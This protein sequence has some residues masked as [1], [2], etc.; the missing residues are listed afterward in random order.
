M[1][2]N[3]TESLGRMPRAQ[4]NVRPVSQVTMAITASDL[5]VQFG[6]VQQEVLRW[7]R[8][9]AG[10]SLPKQAWKGESFELTEIG[11]QPVEATFLKEKHYW[12]ARLDD[13]DKSTPD[14]S[15]V[16]ETAIAKDK[17]NE[18]ILF[19][20]RLTCV[21]RGEDTPFD[22]TIPGFVRQIVSKFGGIIDGRM[23][24]K[25]PWIVD[26]PEEVQVLIKLITNPNR[27][28][29][30]IVISTQGQSNEVPPTLISANSVAER[31][32][33]AA[34]IVVITTEASYVL[35][36]IVGKELSVFRRAVR[37]YKPDFDLEEAQPYDHSLAVESRI[38]GWTG[39]PQAF[40][41]F[42]IASCLRETVRRQNHEKYLPPY[43]EVKRAAKKLQLEHSF[44]KRVKESMT[45]SL[46][47]LQQENKLLRAQ[48]EEYEMELRN[49]EK[50]A[51][52]L[53]DETRRKLDD[54][55]E[56]EK[57]IRSENWRLKV[58]INHLERNDGVVQSHTLQIPTSFEDLQDWS[59]KHLSGKVYLHNRAVRSAKGSKFENVALAYRALLILRDFYVPMRLESGDDLRA[60]Y[61]QELKK[62]NLR[63]TSTFAGSRFGQYGDE[64]FVRH[65][66][67]KRKLDRHL[68]GSDSRD[69]RFGFRLYFFWDDDNG[70]VVVG[71]LPS[72]LKTDIS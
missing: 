15:W 13:A 26:T 60:R 47:G 54:A 42:L 27:N 43:I 72:H 6:N 69:P 24:S 50:A 31:L 7:M 56:T 18:R 12:A 66:G 39:G 49:T 34:H 41:N 36:S 46:E 16:T 21:T 48:L 11:S 5:D 44:S 53:V 29:D 64:Y 19:G 28:Q 37:T 52:E 10:K 9:R 33:G 59:N 61:V 62:E 58:R 40:E 35:T 23:I 32:L 22:P 65:G 4:A 25:E 67:R 63:E 70:E 14:R 17:N 20:A 3:L 45:K 55:M 2:R 30:V 1:T 68:K 8:N 71:S 38:R 51:Y 57:E